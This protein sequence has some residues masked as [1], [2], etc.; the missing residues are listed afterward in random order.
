MTYRTLAGHS[1]GQSIG[2]PA[3]SRLKGRWEA[4]ASKPKAQMRQRRWSPRRFVL[5][6]V[7][8]NAALWV[9]TGALVWWGL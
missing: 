6:T 3:V 5:S 8:F 7:S 9:V 1:F 2:N 4:A